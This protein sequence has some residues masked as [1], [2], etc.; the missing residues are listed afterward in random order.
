MITFMLGIIVGLMI[1]KYL[2]MSA[3]YG[4]LWIFN[5]DKK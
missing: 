5:R 4:W 1:G 3:K 2:E